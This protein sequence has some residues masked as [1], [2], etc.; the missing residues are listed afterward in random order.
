LRVVE[1]HLPNLVYHTP[2]A[3][4]VENLHCRRTGTGIG[5]HRLSTTTMTSEFVERGVVA[6]VDAPG[7]V[8]P[9]LHYG[10]YGA[11]ADHCQ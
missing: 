4:V 2:V 5:Y 6:G 9:L 10:V 3:P 1:E 8:E 7:L 11:R